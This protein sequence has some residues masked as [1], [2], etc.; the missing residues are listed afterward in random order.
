ME[1]K[2]KKPADVPH[3]G[4]QDKVMILVVVYLAPMY[5][6]K[7]IFLTKIWQSF[8]FKKNNWL[9]QLSKQ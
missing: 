5:I 7:K 9:N 8:F 6:T 1:P 2:K 4:R 3:K